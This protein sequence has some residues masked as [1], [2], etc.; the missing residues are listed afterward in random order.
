MEINFTK[1]SGEW[2]SGEGPESD[3]VISSRIRLARNINI[4]PFMARMNATQRQEL[5]A[6]V[7]GKIEK[8]DFPSK[9][10]YYRLDDV[11]EMDLEYLVERHLISRDLANMHGAKSVAIGEKEITSIMVNEE[12]HLR[13]QTL[14]SGFQL[15]RLWSLTDEID[16]VLDE[17]LPYSFHPQFGYLTACPTNVGTG[18]RV[19][20][21]LHLPG[22]ALTNQIEKVFYA[23]SKISLAVRGLYGEGSNASSDFYQIS[24]QI[25]LGKTEEQL[26]DNL[27]S[28]VPQIIRYEKEARQK[29]FHDDRNNLEDKI[30]RAWGIMKN[31]RVLSLEECLDHMSTLRLGVNLKILDNVPIAKLNELFILSLPAHLQKRADKTLNDLERNKVRAEH[32]REIFSKL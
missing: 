5:E 25:T 26:L 16:D 30:Y 9:L 4:F 2:L 13:I 1:T 8:L 6:F 29:L 14:L 22:L 32:V 20:V 12:D 17:V 21:M 31:A 15:D 10:T 24:N 28:V 23:V 3:I 19:S 11:S 27:K 18:M 7:R